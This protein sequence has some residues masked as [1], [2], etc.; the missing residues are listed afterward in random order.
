MSAR[1]PLLLDRTRAVVIAVDMQEPFL[2]TIFERDRVVSH[3]RLLIEAA[4]TLNVPIVA[5][6]QYAERMG[7]L[8]PDITDALGSSQISTFDKMT[9]S[10]CGSDEVNI[11]IADSGRKQVLLCG[12]ESH[13][14]IA[15]TALDL[16]QQGYQVHVAL[17][18][19]S[20]RTASRHEIG[21]RKVLAAGVTGCSSEQAVF[22]MLETA[23]AS[24]FKSIHAL[25]K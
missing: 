12:V 6:L 23:S 25:V 7:G 14:C 17:D 16:M 18:A 1:H 20:S 3:C 2:R 13:I 21:L 15:Q 4:R 5:T 24:E 10:C 22:E 9:F 11:A 8:V 19:V